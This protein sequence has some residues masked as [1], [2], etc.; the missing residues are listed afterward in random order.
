MTF[1]FLHYI[2]YFGDNIIIQMSCVHHK[3]ITFS[4]SKYNNI[5][6]SKMACRLINLSLINNRCVDAVYDGQLPT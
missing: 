4:I 2:Y 6:S 5:Y 3:N 1:T